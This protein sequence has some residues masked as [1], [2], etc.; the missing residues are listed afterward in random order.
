MS[1]VMLIEDEPVLRSSMSRC[2]ARL[3][4]VEVVDASLLRDAMRLLDAERPDLIISDLDLPDGSGIEILA[5]MDQLGLRVPVIFV[6]AYLR[7]FRGQLPERGDIEVYEKP[8]SLA[9][10]REIVVRHLDV[11]QSVAHD[12]PFTLADYLQLACMGRHSV[13]LEVSRQGD[14]VGQITVV[15]GQ[16]WSAEAGRERGEDAVATLAFGIAGAQTEVRRLR[17]QPG[18]RDVQR[19]WQHILL[20]A[21]RVHDEAVRN[22][23]GRASDS[24]ES[25]APREPQPAPISVAP[26]PSPASSRP[27]T[28]APRTPSNAPRRVASAAPRG[29]GSYIFGQLPESTPPPAASEPPATV[30]PTAVV[31]QTPTTLLRPDLPRIEDGRSRPQLPRLPRDRA[32]TPPPLRPSGA[33]RALRPPAQ[34]EKAPWSA[35]TPPLVTSDAPAETPVEAAVEAPVEGDFEALMDDGLD[36]MLRRDYPAAW[37]ALSRADQIRPDVPTVLANLAR[38]RHLGYGDEA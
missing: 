14:V 12:S 16:V 5:A 22:R 4:D 21:A 37:V 23:G 27:G 24:I 7:S 25:I 11:R 30:P 20:N 29:K 33:P 9:R 34:S 13:R 31:D 10:L 38:L 1:L 35:P 6:T 8:L 26:R 18:A 3:P 17:S 2:L 15:Q 19:P 28:I 32:P 36:A